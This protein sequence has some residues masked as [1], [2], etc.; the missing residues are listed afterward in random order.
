MWSE[1]DV[2]KATKQRKT[3]A[4]TKKDMLAS[5][6]EFSSS[7][8]MKARQWREEERAYLA[9]IRHVRAAFDSLIP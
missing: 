1:T 8:V 4:S 7:W 2:Q 6:E 9:M 3:Q 5:T